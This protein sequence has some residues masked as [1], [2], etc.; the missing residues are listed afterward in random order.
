MFVYSKFLLGPLPTCSTILASRGK[1]LTGVEQPSAK[2]V[3]PQV[4][5]QDHAKGNIYASNDCTL[6]MCM[7]VMKGRK[8]KVLLLMLPT[9]MKRRYFVSAHFHKKNIMNIASSERFAFQ[10]EC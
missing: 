5:S 3:M 10:T 9:M 4:K 7:Y 8:I 2:D 6:C 1:E